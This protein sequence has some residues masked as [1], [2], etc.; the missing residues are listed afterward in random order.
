MIEKP[1]FS[2]K[3]QEIASSGETESGNVTSTFSDHP[4]IF[5]FLQIFFSKVSVTKSNILR[6]DWKKFES[7]KF[8][9]DFNQINWSK[10]YKMRK[11]MSII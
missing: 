5:I 7:S 8:I 1:G 4:P 3:P 6:R 11:M 10:F 9:S 2:S